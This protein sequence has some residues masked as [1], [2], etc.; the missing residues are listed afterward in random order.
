MDFL[1][2]IV[3]EGR[4]SMEKALNHLQDEMSTVRAGRANPS[5]LN[6]VMVEAYG[7][8]MPLNQTANVSTPDARTISIKPW[9]KAMLPEIEKAIMMANIGLTPQNDGEQIRLNIPPLTEERRKDLVKQV[10]SLGENAKVAS[11]NARR[12]AI[13]GV[14]KKGKEESVSEDTI[15]DY[16]ATIQKLTDEFAK[17]IDEAISNKEKEIMTV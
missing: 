14:Q 10:K 5:L 4:A 15:K 2:T 1:D 9:D 13:S 6:N 3:Q 7:S 16:E 8:P 12:D 17:K 11:R